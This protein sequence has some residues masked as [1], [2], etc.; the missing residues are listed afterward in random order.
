[1]SCIQF[2]NY[3]VES[4]LYRTLLDIYNGEEELADEA[5]KYFESEIFIDKFG[6]YATEDGGMYDDKHLDSRTDIHGEPL[7]SFNETIQRHYYQD[8]QGEP[9]FYPDNEGLRQHLDTSEIKT[10]AQFLAYSFFSDHI[11]F[12]YSDLSFTNKLDADLKK[13]LVKLVKD[14]SSELQGK[15]NNRD[16]RALGKELAKTMPNMEEWVKE[17]KLIFKQKK[18]AIKASEVKLGEAEGKDNL[19]RKDSFESSAKDSVNNNIKLF[20]S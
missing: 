8:Q 5:Y 17:V 7:L 19:Y 15:G 11:D 18:I 10:F 9:I 16:T 12:S 14:K 2:N 1:M 3:A 6:V 20:L 13:E 4:E